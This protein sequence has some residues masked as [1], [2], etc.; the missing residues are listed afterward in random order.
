VAQHSFDEASVARIVF[1]KQNVNL[2]P[3]HWS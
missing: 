1:N 3:G 2:T